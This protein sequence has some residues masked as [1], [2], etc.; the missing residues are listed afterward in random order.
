MVVFQIMW[1]AN[2]RK[3][4]RGTKSLL[5]QLSSTRLF[6]D[7]FLWGPYFFF[8]SVCPSHRCTPPTSFTSFLSSNTEISV[9]KCFQMLH[10][11]IYTGAPADTCN[12]FFKPPH[13][14]GNCSAKCHILRVPPNP[15]YPSSKCLGY[16]W[17][18]PFPNFHAQFS[19]LVILVLSSWVYHPLCLSFSFL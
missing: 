13:Q 1:K 8:T 19:Y 3:R 2:N 9:S 12:T 5:I 6:L 14:K 4:H 15:S 16:F 11:Y 10:I 7:W 17:H 18:P